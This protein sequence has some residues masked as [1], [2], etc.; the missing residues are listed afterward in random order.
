MYD[1]EVR[2]GSLLFLMARCSTTSDFLGLMH[3]TVFFL[4]MLLRMKAGMIAGA[5]AR[6]EGSGGGRY[7]W[8]HNTATNTC[9]HRLRHWPASHAAGWRRW[10]VDRFSSAQ[11]GIG[12]SPAEDLMREGGRV[13]ENLLQTVERLDNVVGG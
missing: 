7:R 4:L 12:E 11:V 1:F 6:K 10:Q 8:D 2:N 3:R 5:A 13:G 9:R